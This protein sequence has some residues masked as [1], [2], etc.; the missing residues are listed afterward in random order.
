MSS[1]KREFTHKSSSEQRKV[2][3]RVESDPVSNSLL[4]TRHLKTNHPPEDFKDLRSYGVKKISRGSW[5][6]SQRE[7]LGLIK[8]RKVEIIVMMV[9]K[10]MMMIQ[11]QDFG[12]GVGTDV[13]RKKDT[14]VSCEGN[15]NLN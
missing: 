12:R 4:S 13:V 5:S 6:H 14:G 7:W 2:Q 10:M 8:W 15:E 1:N 9:L 11:E 3:C